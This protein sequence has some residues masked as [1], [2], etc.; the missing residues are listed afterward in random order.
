MRRGVVAFVALL[1][2]SIVITSVAWS[3]GAQRLPGVPAYAQNYKRFP[4]LNRRPI[5]IAATAHPSSF[6]NVYVSK[7]RARNG[8]YPYGTLIVKEGV[9]SGRVTL[10][11]VMRKLRGANPR[12]ND[13]RFIEWTRPGSGRFSKVAAPESVCTGCHQMARS[14]DFVFTR[15]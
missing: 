12:Y 2:P 9:T 1:L 11:A 8:R 10:I 14:N 6:R 4:K 5:R 13:W 7:R 15:R 3:S